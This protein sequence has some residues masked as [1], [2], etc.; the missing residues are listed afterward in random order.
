MYRTSNAKALDTLSSAPH[1]G[2]SS[3]LF[4]NGNLRSPQFVP[5]VAR[6]HESIRPS[7]ESSNL[8]VRDIC[9]MKAGFN[10]KQRDE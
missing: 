1:T 10:F 5:A 7:H 6:K 2:Q 4:L 9:G 8:T 3:Q